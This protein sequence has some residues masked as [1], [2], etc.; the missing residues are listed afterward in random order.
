VVK[1]SEE[2]LQIEVEVRIEDLDYIPGEIGG[3]R[4]VIAFDLDPSQAGKVR[5]GLGLVNFGV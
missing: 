2:R 5:A 3:K 1:W 4:K